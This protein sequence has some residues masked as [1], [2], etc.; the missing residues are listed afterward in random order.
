MSIV[1]RAKNIVLKPADEWNVI[2]DEPATVRRLFTGY[3]M[4]LAAIPL[5]ADIIFTGALGINVASFGG[6]G[7]GALEMG[8]GTI[9]AMAV[10][11]YVFSLATLFV[12]SFLVNSV[13]PSFNG[14]SDM[15]QSTKLMTY[16]ST[17]T[18]VVG[19]AG[20]IPIL[21]SLLS[22]AAIAYVVYL[23]YL[24]LQPVLGVPQEK[25]AGFTVVIV[26]IYV[27]MAVIVSGILIGIAL[28]TLSGGGM[29]G[30]ALS[31]A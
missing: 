8:F 2:A 6:V 16:A 5:A 9:A 14:K 13:S 1:D 30:G 15:V 20:W 11:G 19:L 7:G 3:A 25:V 31:G 27:V 22:F 28:P 4:I 26:L 29:M 23:I 24:G 17:P 12:M 21:G 10:V 18:W